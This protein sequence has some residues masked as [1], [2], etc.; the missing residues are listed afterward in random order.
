MIHGVVF[1]QVKFHFECNDQRYKAT[2]GSL[3]QSLDD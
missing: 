2:E 1:V 3:C